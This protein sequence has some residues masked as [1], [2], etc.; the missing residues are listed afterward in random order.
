MTLVVLAWCIL[1]AGSGLTAWP[2]PRVPRWV[3]LIAGAS[4]AIVI[5]AA[6]CV[7]AIPMRMEVLVGVAWWFSFVASTIEGATPGRDVGRSLLVLSAFL[8]LSQAQNWVGLLLCLEL[9]RVATLSWVDRKA[10]LGEMTCT[11]ILGL[12]LAA[13][14]T[15]FGTTALLPGV[16]NAT[17]SPFGPPWLITATTLLAIGVCWP[18]FWCWRM[19]LASEAD[20]SLGQR[21]AALTARQGMA[22]FLL[23]QLVPQTRVE[24]ETLGLVLSLIVVATCGVSLRS[25]W[26]IRQLEGCLMAAAHLA[27]SAS[28]LDRLLGCVF[29]PEIAT[30]YTII[31]PSTVPSNSSLFLFNQLLGLGG[32]V[33][34]LRWLVESRHG[35]TTAVYD[36]QL[37]GLGRTASRRS[38]L[39]LVLLAT[40]TAVPP[41]FGFLGVARLVH[42]FGVM[43]MSL[44]DVAVP[45]ILE[46]IAILS[47]VEL[48]LLLLLWVAA[49]RI[50]R[51]VMLDP[52]LAR[53]APFAWSPQG[54]GASLAGIIVLVASL[55]SLLM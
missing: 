13:R 48:P 16:A 28:L 3:A 49:Y 41:T 18:V 36:D 51:R 34:C 54:L 38:V 32:V 21:L 47:V 19:M 37:R 20:V 1:A 2:S 42:H 35:A 39:L 55:G 46:L 44:R 8:L 14:A 23:Q 25:L 10:H 29:P 43:A 6:G 12:A 31:A 30:S 45:G 52:P 50:V 4:V 26:D 17:L 53:A 9:V 5:V 33:M 24:S 40:A 15:V 27:W 7:S 11:L 22:W